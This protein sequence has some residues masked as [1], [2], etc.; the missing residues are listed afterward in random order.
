MP[1]LNGHLVFSK[2]VVVSEI[3]AQGRNDMIGCAVIFF[4]AGEYIII[5]IKTI[6]KKITTLL[7][8]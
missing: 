2:V 6:I 5:I 7:P 3:P 1:G 8:L 4:T